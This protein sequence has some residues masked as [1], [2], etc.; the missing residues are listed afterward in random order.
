MGNYC[1]QNKQKKKEKTPSMPQLKQ[2]NLIR[3]DRRGYWHESNVCG[4]KKVM[5]C[6]TFVCLSV[7]LLFLC[8]LGH[9]IELS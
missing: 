4:I 1:A 9:F 6:S 3:I 5:K 2:D 8:S 7:N